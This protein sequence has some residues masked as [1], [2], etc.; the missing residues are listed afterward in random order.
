MECPASIRL[1][2][3]DRSNLQMGRGYHPN[4]IIE[5]ET[6]FAAQYGGSG[7]RRT[8][9]QWQR[10]LWGFVCSAGTADRA[11]VGVRP[12]EAG[13]ERLACPDDLRMT[14][15]QRAS[16]MEQLGYSFDR[17]VHL[18]GVYRVRY[19]LASSDVVT[20]E[21]WRRR[22]SGFVVKAGKADRVMTP[23]GEMPGKPAVFEVNEPRPAPAPSG[24][25]PQPMTDEERAAA[26]EYWKKPYVAKNAAIKPGV[27]AAAVIPA[28]DLERL[29]RLQEE[30]RRRFAE[31]ASAAKAG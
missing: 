2:E 23:R 1:S 8:S 3:A 6:R 18:E 10:R 29:Q 19:G 15:R 26:L 30:A 24:P 25:P 17:I 11:A 22:L 21:E 7:E 27:A 12:A 31:M 14:D 5:L 4:R 9:Q 16:I 20:L 28:A 13:V